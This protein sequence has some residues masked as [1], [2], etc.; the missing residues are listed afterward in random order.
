MSQ[1]LRMGLPAF[2]IG[3]FSNSGPYHKEDGS[4]FWKKDRMGVDA[5]PCACERASDAKAV[6]NA[7][8]RHLLTTIAPA[9]CDGLVAVWLIGKKC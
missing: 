3:C 2:I 1:N 5:S 6:S 7:R 9:M 4:C 8:S